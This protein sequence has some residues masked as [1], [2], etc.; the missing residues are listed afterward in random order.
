MSKRK[1]RKARSRRRTG[2][3][4]RRLERLGLTLVSVASGVALAWWMLEMPLLWI[5]GTASIR[6]V[7]LG[8]PE[9]ES[10]DLGV[11][12]VSIPSIV[13]SAPPAAEQSGPADPPAPAARVFV[14]RVPLAR[15][16]PAARRSRETAAPGNSSA[17]PIPSSGRIRPPP[18]RPRTQM[19]AA[20]PPRNSG[21]AVQVA[22]GPNR[23][24]AER[25]ER[26]LRNQGFSSYVVAFQDGAAGLRY[27]VRVRPKRGEGVDELMERLRKRGHTGWVVRR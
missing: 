26:R 19:R 11:G 22:A 27:K 8:P 24:G 2:S 10:Q 15:P 7:S 1:R 25:L 16:T 21:P 18:P 3:L 12:S 14:P 6:E 4:R 9:R 20:S 13:R 17:R 23:S 5:R